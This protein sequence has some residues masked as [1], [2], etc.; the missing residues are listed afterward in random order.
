VQLATAMIALD[1]GLAVQH[2]VDP[3][4]AP[5]DDYVLLFDLL[6]GQLLDPGTK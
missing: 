5:L 6:F 3:E 1:V 4:E 2:L